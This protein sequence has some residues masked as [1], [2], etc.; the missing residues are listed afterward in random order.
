MRFLFI[1]ILFLLACGWGCAPQREDDYDLSGT[2]PA[3]E[4]S[5][6]YVTGDSNSIVIKDLSNTGFQ[7]LWDLPSGNPKTSTLA[8]DTVRYDKKGTYTITL[9]VSQKDGS[10]TGVTTRQVIIPNDAPVTCSPK[11]ALLTG[12]CGPG[13]K[14]W[15]LAKEA[16]AVKV[17]PTYDDYS[18]YT[19]PVN[20][21]QNEQYDDS[22]CFTFDKLTYENRNNG[23][24]VNPWNGYKP[25]PYKAD[26]GDFVFSEGSGILG[27]DQLILPD[28]Q[29]MGV[30]DMHNTLDIVKLTATE[31]IVRGRQR[32]QDGKAL[33]QGWF[34]LRFVAR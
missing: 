13:G 34:E 9:Y 30:W 31:L 25:E 21:L 2:A 1:S 5:I 15:T 11:M 6:A 33:P 20:G 26:P 19:S 10:G 24:S 8:V 18:W 23:A 27:R 32:A 29:W 4:I 28:K 17:G 3:P 22:F 16:G 7:R 12:D 14:C